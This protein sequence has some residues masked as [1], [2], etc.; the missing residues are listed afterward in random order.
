MC[1]S[2]EEKYAKN[3]ARIL[4]LDRRRKRIRELND[5]L[6]INLSGGLIMLT[7]GIKGLPAGYVCSIITAVSAFD[8]FD[9]D[10]PYGEHD[11]GSIDIGI[12]KVFWKI[13]CY[14]KALEYGS[15]DAAQPD[16]TT[17]VLTIMLAEEY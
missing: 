7:P 2:D 8:A 15:P 6:R 17:R 9:I 13:D 5:A 14:D 4:E 10:D 3:T 12:Q 16:L 1:G 11:F